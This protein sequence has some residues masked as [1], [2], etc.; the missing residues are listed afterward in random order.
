VDYRRARAIVRQLAREADVVHT[1][2]LPGLLP[3]LVGRPGGGAPWVH[4]E[5][6]SGVTSP[7]T[8]TP[9][10]RMLR[11][12]LM[13]KLAEPDAVIAQCERL[14]GTIARVRTGRVDLVPCIVDDPERVVAPPRDPGLLRL[15]GV[16]GLVARKGPLVALGAVKELLARGTAAELTWVG[17]GPLRSEMLARAEDLGIPDR[18]RLTGTLSPAGVSAQLDAAD[19]F[20]LP[21]LGDNFCVVVA[22]ALVHGRPIVSGSD[23]GAVDYSDARVSEFVAEHTPSA[24]AD[25]IRRVAVKTEELSAH[26]IAGTVRGAFSSQLVAR[27]L[28]EVYRAVARA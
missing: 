19:V 12:V 26:D 28:T 4:T 9:V 2:A 13:R 10:E 18:L 20:V 8:L 15:V 21:T 5:H 23:T 6:W 3:F 25:A 27:R 7:A 24:F 14:A 1:H 11:G 16:G 17:D 22:E